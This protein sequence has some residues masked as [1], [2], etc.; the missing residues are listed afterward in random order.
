MTI[1]LQGLLA[2]DTARL[3]E[4]S[5]EWDRL[6][7]AL[8]TAVE[9]LGRETRDL[10]H[11]W[12]TSADAQDRGADLR[13]QLGTGYGHCAAIA[14]AVREFAGEVEDNRRL[15]HGLVAEARGVGLWI[16]LVSGLITAPIGLAVDAYAQQI[17]EIVARVNEADRRTVEALELH[18]YREEQVPPTEPP[19]YRERG[20]LALAAATPAERASWWR[21]QHPLNQERAILEQPE[22]VGAAV[23]LPDKDRDMANRL[24][25]R[26]AKEDLRAHEG[27]GI[28]QAQLAIIRRL[29]AIDDL[30]QRAGGR[31]LVS[32][33]PG[34]EQDAELR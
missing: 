20:V 10:P 31:R 18:K 27:D 1:T 33:R 11:H 14:T 24:L 34:A 19:E 3:I 28:S 16:D 15:L 23:G 17:A 13:A 21:A 7:A 32:Y 12:P 29:A 30:E 9:E 5:R 4:I 22:I 6:A 26:R 8:D 25:L 2:A